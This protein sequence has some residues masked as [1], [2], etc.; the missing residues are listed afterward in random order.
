VCSD[1]GVGPLR[2]DRQCGNYYLTS[3]ANANP[4]TIYAHGHV[5]L[6]IDGDVSGSAPL[7]FAVEPT[8]TLDILVTGTINTSQQLTIGS[9]DYPALCRLYVGGTANLAFSQN[10]NIGCNIY[11]ANSQLVDWSATC[12]I[13]GSVFAGN[14]KASHDTFIHYDQGVLRAG[15]ECPPPG[16]SG[17]DGGTAP[18]DAGSPTCG[19]CR[20]CNNQACVNG[21]CGAC[22]TRWRLLCSSPVSLRGMQPRNP[23]LT[24][25][26]ARR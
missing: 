10:A 11:A 5:G 3:V 6:Y 18:P 13:Y 12:A 19:S 8:A 9:T 4:L 20:D 14:F 24:P 7:A 25:H 21:T 26:L 1:A 15:T 17:S 16:G 2:V 23:A 22:T